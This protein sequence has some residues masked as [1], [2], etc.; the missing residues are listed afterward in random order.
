VII[1]WALELAENPNTHV[2]LRAGHE[3]IVSDR[4]VLWLGGGDHPAWNVAQRFRFPAEELASVRDEIRAHMRGRGRT[5]CSWEVGS[6]AMP[7]DLV[8]RLLK[9][10]FVEHEEPLRI[11]MALRAPPSGASEVEVRHAESADEHRAAARIASVVFGVPYLEPP[12]PDPG[13]CVYLA[14]LEGEPVGRAT[15][16][17]SDHG[18][19]LFGAAVMP[20]ARGR[21]AYRSLVHARW[22][23]AV[24]R[25]TPLAVT[26]AGSQSYPILAEM[27]FEEVCTIHALS[28]RFA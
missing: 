28:D 27:G 6:S 22:R 12:P 15:G 9:I 7:V 10:G 2:P 8:E 21:G 24:A 4:Y 20:A 14:Y 26:D 25:G 1:D 5:V 13:T 18:V 23:D 11:G 3:R 19:T 17:F 16:S